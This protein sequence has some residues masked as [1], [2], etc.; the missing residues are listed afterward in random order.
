MNLFILKKYLQTNDPG[1]QLYG[2][3]RDQALTIAVANKIDKT[4]HI[5]K[6]DD[7]FAIFASDGVFDNFIGTSYTRDTMLVNFPVVE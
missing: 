7:D 4:M 1:F 6:I 3:N 2:C 5:S